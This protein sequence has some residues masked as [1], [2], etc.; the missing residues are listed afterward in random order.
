MSHEEPIHARAGSSDRAGTHSRRNPEW[1]AIALIV[2]TCIAG[3]LARSIPTARAANDP[4]H[5]A[6]TITTGEAGPVRLTARLDREAV[7]DRGDGTVMVELTLRGAEAVGSTPVRTPTDL[8]VLLDRSGSMEGE[9]MAHA[10][11]S[12]LALI[13]RLVSA[14]RFALVSYADGARIDVPLEAAHGDAADRWSRQVAA[15]AAGGGTDM[16]SG[17]DLAHRLLEAS[18]ASGRTARLIVISDGHANQ[19]DATPQGLRARAGRAVPAEYVL[20]AVGVGDGFDEQLMT[21]LANAGTGNFYYVD[22]VEKLARIFSEELLAARETVARTL[23]IEL[24]PMQGVSV[25]EAAGYPIERAGGRAVVRPGSLFAGQ[26]RRIWLTLAI[27]QGR[28]QASQDA[29]ALGTFAVAFRTPDGSAQRVALGAMPAVRVVHD[30]ADFAAAR[31]A[32]AYVAQLQSEGLGLLRAKVARAVSDGDAA[33][34]SEYIEEF[35]TA[36]V[37]ELRSLGYARPEQDAAIAAA[38]ELK[39]E[40]AEAMAPSAPAAARSRLGKKLSEQAFDGRRQGAKRSEA[41]GAVE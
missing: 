8:L 14:D 16:S 38:I 30:D 12:T 1:I 34:A 29:I 9:A 20:S 32:S 25:V 13:G 17:L 15:I 37:A 26:E 35:E 18:R 33:R 7:M 27:D 31:D 10:R 28:R 4:G 5:E 36:N 40:V 19:G 6:R 41:D 21:S 3:G 23:A 24:E 11:A 39:Q 2:L 22:D